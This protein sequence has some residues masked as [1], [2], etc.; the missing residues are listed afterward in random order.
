MSITAKDVNKLRSRTGAGMMD[1][2]N[3]LKQSGGD[4]EN[5][6][7]ILRKRGQKISNKRS[8]RE[9]LEGSIFVKVN[10][11]NDLGIIIALSCET[12]FVAKN[13]KFLE[14]GNN[15]IDTAL[16]Y[17]PTNIDQLNNLEING[18]KVSD[19]ITDYIGKIGEKIEIK[20][21]DRI[22]APLVIPY[23][24]TGNNLGVLVGLE[25]I[26]NEK[27]KAILAGKDIAMQIAAMNPIALSKEKIDP[28]TIKKELDIAKEQA[29]MEGKPEAVTEKIAHGKL[30]KF[31]KE[32][33][34]LHQNYIK[35]PSITIEKYLE[36]IHKDLKITDYKR[37]SI[38]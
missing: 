37:I 33:T 20:H 31:F 38:K 28:D 25:G 12:D 7:D 32:N 4:F 2:K 9:A 27:H 26:N 22:K 24:H 15:I 13:E 30:N 3:A 29:K 11:S 5:A 16:T 21:F 34:L 17:N 18:T 23:I 14:L 1:C 19:I 10:G 8:E 35:D 36:S 6:V